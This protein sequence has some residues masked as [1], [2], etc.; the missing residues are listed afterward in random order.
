MEEIWKDVVGYEGYY[1]VSNMGNVKSIDRYVKHSI[2]GLPTK[3][4]GKTLKANIN[5]GYQEINLSK[6]GVIKDA[7]ISRLVAIAFIPNPENK[8]TVNHKNGI[9]NDDRVE[10][11]EWNT[12]QENNIHAYKVLKRKSAFQG[13]FGELNYSAKKIKCTTTDEVFTTMKEACEKY[14]LD[15]SS[16]VKICKGKR[17]STKGLVFQ[18]V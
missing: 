6:L 11:L 5:H 9:R 3:R 12:Q 14:E 17:K 13:R 10:N 4:K 18:Y 2:T 15:M 16:V 7:K 1:K 8:A